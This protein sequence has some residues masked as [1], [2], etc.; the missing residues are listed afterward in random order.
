MKA[1]LFDM[2]GVL[3]NSEPV[4]IEASLRT[5]RKYGVEAKETDFKEFTGMGDDL[6]IGGVARKNCVE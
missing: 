6:F 1:V 2:D 4:I 5:L 3:V